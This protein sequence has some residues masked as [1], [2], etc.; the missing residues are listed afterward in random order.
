MKF[1]ANEST[2]PRVGVVY[3][4]A[5]VDAGMVDAGIRSGMDGVVVAGTGNGTVHAEL[6]AVL[7]AAMAWAA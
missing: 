3:S 6:E 4:H 5:G 1:I 2:W 7:L